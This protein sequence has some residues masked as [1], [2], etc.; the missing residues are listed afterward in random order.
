[1]AGMARKKHQKSKVPRK[2]RKGRV[3]EQAITRRGRRIYA[4]GQIRTLTGNIWGVASQGPEGLSL[5]HI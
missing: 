1:M 3:P 2:P 5:I 4:E